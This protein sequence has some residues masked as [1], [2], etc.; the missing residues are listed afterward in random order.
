M[1]AIDERAVNRMMFNPWAVYVAAVGD[2]QPADPSFYTERGIGIN[3][4]LEFVNAEA[5]NVCAGVSYTVRQDP[6]RFSLRC[7]WSIKEFVA[8]T[9]Q[10]VYGGTID[11][12][13][14]LLTFDGTAP[15]YKAVWLQTCYSDDEKIV[16]L[17]M[18]RGRSVDT[19][20]F[21]SGDTHIV[22]PTTWE[23]LPEIDDTSTLPTLYFE[24]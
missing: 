15:P 5:Y 8:I 3:P 24:P 2:A 22:L 16:R 20:E 14:N 18:P 19:A 6:I 1:A 7:T 13:N 10:L 23:S 12:T 4:M 11:S 21:A 17:T 9:T